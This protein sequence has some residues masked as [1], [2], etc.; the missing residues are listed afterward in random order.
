VQR[1]EFVP[2]P[3]EV[4]AL[5]RGRSTR[6]GQLEEAIPEEQLAAL[7]GDDYEQ[8]ESE[9][10]W[11]HAL[12]FNLERGSPTTTSGL[13]SSCRVRARPGGPRRPDHVRAR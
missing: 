7:D 5:Q 11:N 12:H 4:L 13:P 3:D 10:D 9:G 6:R 8:I 2:A 1:L